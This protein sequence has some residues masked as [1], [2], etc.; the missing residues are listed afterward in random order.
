M[1]YLLRGGPRDRQLVDDLPRGYRPAPELDMEVVRTRFEE[2][3]F[4]AA[5]WADGDAG[6]ASHASHAPRPRLKAL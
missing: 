4:D 2:L 1:A 5:V 3:Q 6:A